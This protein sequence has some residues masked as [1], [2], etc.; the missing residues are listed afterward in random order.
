MNRVSAFIDRRHGPIFMGGRV[1]RSARAALV[2]ASIP[3]IIAT[4]SRAALADPSAP[5]PA[6]RDSIYLKNGGIIRGTPVDA[7]PGDHA[8]IEL[9]THE[10]QSVAWA[11]VLRI[12][13]GA[14][15]PPA[16][17]SSAGTL[18]PTQ[19]LV[20]VHRGRSPRR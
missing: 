5:A 20:L 17:P 7:I 2:A 9:V 18:S 8:R 4:S 19:S 14:A 10:I 6:A 1:F 15:P 3:V 16:A 12:E 13:H 11:D